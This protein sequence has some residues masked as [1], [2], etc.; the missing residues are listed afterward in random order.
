VRLADMQKV[1]REA[2]ERD[3]DKWPSRGAARVEDE[4]AHYVLQSFAARGFAAYAVDLRGYGDTPRDATG[5]LTPKR[6]AADI[7]NVVAWIGT[8][9]AALP[10]PT[11]VGWSRGAIMAGM[12]AIDAPARISNLVL[13]GFAFD[14]VLKFSEVPLL[15]SPVRERNTAAAATADFISPYVTPRIVVEAFVA[16]ALKTD[17]VL[18]DVKNDGEF[19]AFVPARVATPTLV[20][21]G[22]ND[23]GVTDDD[24]GKMFAALG[25]TD[26][27]VVALPGGDHAAQL[28]DTHNA[29]IAA[30][31]NFIDRAGRR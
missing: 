14:P 1:Y 24:V 26:K 29:W 10:R 21:Y 25:T 30:I 15:S 11:V 7:V 31:V 6:S 17:P 23:P 19:N 27:Q 4:A 12:A 2:F 5:W 18:V 28:E 22:S 20:L 3:Q 13:F 8:Q 9:H 16:Q